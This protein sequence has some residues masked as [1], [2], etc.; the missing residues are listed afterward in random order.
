MMK[1]ESKVEVLISS[2]EFLDLSLALAQEMCNVYT[3]IDVSI[4]V[5]I[6]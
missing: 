2:T 5:C 4:I 6:L 1:P 3:D